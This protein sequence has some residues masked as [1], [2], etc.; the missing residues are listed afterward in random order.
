[1]K[2]NAIGVDK[3]INYIMGKLNKA[4]NVNASW[5]I[6]IYHKVYRE[7]DA[8]DKFAPYAFLA[9]KE[10]KEVF[11]NDRV[12]GEVGFYL[13]N[14]RPVDGF[15]NV[16]CDIIFSVN[17]DRLDNG[18]LKREDERAI[19]MAYEAVDGSR[20]SI[21]EVKTELRG[22]FSQFDQERIKY[23]DMQPYLNFSFTVNLIY[24]N[25]NCY[26]M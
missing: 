21:T 5:G 9:Q 26:G 2:E 17:L 20:S 10:Y 23:R 15:T 6:E 1:L 24:K 22:V 14:T 25:N 4:L 7:R 19:M 11:L 8:K 3:E 16:D 18:S 13:N 12:I